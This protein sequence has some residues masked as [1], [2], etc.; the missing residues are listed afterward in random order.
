MTSKGNRYNEEFKADII[1]LIREENQPVDK[2]AKDFDVNAQTIRN[3]LKSAMTKENPI[4]NRVTELEAQLKAEK[5][6][7]ADSEQTVNILKKS[8]SIFIQDSRK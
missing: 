1:R 6:K 7:N 2:V 4:N 8:V 3:W 5:R